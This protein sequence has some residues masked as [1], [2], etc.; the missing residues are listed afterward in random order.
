MAHLTSEQIQSLRSQLMAEKRGIEHQLEQNDHYG[1]SGSMRFQTGELSLSII[2]PVML[3][4]R[5][6]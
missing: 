3:S 4:Y 6:V 2:I 5:N 1:L